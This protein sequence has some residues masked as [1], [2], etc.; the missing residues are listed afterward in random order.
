M[1]VTHGLEKRNLTMHFKMSHKTVFLVKS[2]HILLRKCP[3]FFPLVS[4]DSSVC[5]QPFILAKLSPTTTR[6][7]SCSFSLQAAN[8]LISG[9]SVN[10]RAEAEQS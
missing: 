10:H 6:C 2:G 3:L 1:T 8:M 9:T 5:L 4:Y 7:C